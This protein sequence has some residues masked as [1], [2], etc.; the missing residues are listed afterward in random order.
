MK[1]D[2]T[3]SNAKEYIEVEINDAPSGSHVDGDFYTLEELDQLEDQSMASVMRQFSNMRFRRDP[4]HKVKPTAYRYKG[5]SS[6][7]GSRSGYKTG[8]VDRSKIRCYNCN[9]LGHLSIECRRPKQARKG[10]SPSGKAF[11]VKGKSWDDS[12]NDDDEVV[13]NLALMASSGKS[14]SSTSSSRTE[15]KFTDA[16][17]ISNL[18]HTLDCAQRTRAKDVIKI[19]ELETEL[20]ALK[21]VH[22]NQD[23][24]EKEV[25]FLENKVKCHKEIETFLK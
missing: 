25:V 23:K 5:G 15:V 2:I 10:D 20:E 3:L 14:S 9:E 21:L 13:G 11:L 4:R 18:Y 19:T 1:V 6:G 17:L 7:S 22:I 24:L 8:A 16:E 12:D